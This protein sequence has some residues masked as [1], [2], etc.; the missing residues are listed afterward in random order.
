MI[1]E[2]TIHEFRKFNNCSI[3]LGR[4]LTAIAG[5]NATGKST[6]LALLGHCAE[7]DTDIA[8][9]IGGTQ[10]RT[11]FGQIMKVDA[12]KDVKSDNLMT[13]TICSPNEMDVIE[14]FH[15]RST[16]QGEIDI[17][18]FRLEKLMAKKHLAKCNGRFYI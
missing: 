6:I 18:F 17:E 10:Y 2:L 9:P 1:S 14:T 13:F 12:E 5:H 16:V 3:S 4:Y 15:Y 8:T 7:L 11:E